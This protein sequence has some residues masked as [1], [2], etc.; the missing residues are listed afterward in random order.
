VGIV[1]G[2]V[3]ALGGP[4][5]ADPTNPAQEQIDQA[6]ADEALA[7]ASVTEIEN[8]LDEL[9]AKSEAAVA[10]AGLAAETYNA[11]AQE[12]DQAQQAANAALATAEQAVTAL[13]LAKGALARVAISASESTGG[14]AAVEP[15]LTA[16]GIDQAL[17]RAELIDIAGTA[18][19]RAA[20]RLSVAQQLAQSAQAR[21]T[22]AVELR[23]SLNLAAERAA[24]AAERAAQ[25]ATA[26]EQAAQNERERLV[27]VLA[28]KRNTTKALVEAAEQARQEA[29]NQAARR[30]AEE[31]QKAADKAA[32]D[33]ASSNP[34]N[35]VTTDQPQP[36]DSSAPTPT[37]K[38][39]KPTPAA[40]PPA[41]V[42]P[43]DAGLAAVE[44]ARQQIG[45]PYKLGGTGPDT[46]DC[47]GLTSQAWLNGGGVAI[48]RTAAW[49]YAA[50]T[51][52]AFDQMRPGDLIFWGSTAESI[53]HVAMYTGDGNMIEAPRTG[54]NVQEIPIRWSG[55][56]G[57]AG[58]F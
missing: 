33:A 57:Y 37:P 21:A 25:S 6:R 15:F 39:N 18:S 19:G 28:A 58:R 48:P 27:T 20:T 42:A 43:S 52:V 50:A 24:T 46:F 16:N 45:K 29:E 30:L 5:G 10:A 26:Q 36:K 12:L 14:F 34:A 55:T 8:L 1:I 7:A 9:Q 4:A 23:E 49:Q 40:D 56:Y 53:Y 54:K 44:W 35:E 51:K 22:Q 2:L 32:R 17:R 47:S 31:R 41:V 11:A 13:N 3:V 38:K